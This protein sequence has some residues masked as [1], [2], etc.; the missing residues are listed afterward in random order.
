M[1]YFGHG[2]LRYDYRLG[3][4]TENSLAEKDLVALIHKKSGQNLQSALATQKAN[5]TLGCHK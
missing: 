4:L 1:L 2:N 5:F 3:E